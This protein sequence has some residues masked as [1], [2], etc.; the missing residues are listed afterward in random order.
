MESPS[1]STKI[2]GTH[3]VGGFTVAYMVASTLA[4]TVADKVAYLV[5]GGVAY[6]VASIVAYLGSD[7][8][9]YLVVGGWHSA[10]PLARVELGRRTLKV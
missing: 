10:L 7:M 5:V 1:C 8:M 6:L 2:E 4:D 3:T 9:A